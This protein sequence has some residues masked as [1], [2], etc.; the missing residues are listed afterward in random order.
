W[1]ASPGSCLNQ[2]C[3][4]HDRCYDDIQIANNECFGVSCTWAAQT[5]SCDQHFFQGAAACDAC[6]SPCNIPCHVIRWIASFAASHNAGKC[7]QPSDAT[8][9]CD[10]GCDV[11]AS[12]G[13]VDLAT[14]EQNPQESVGPVDRFQCTAEGQTC[15][16]GQCSCATGQTLCN[17]ACVDTQS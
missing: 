13:C 8:C 1:W 11:C 3:Y 17:E 2:V 9:S 12:A 14:L 15:Q 5:T 10:Q 4:A 7:D 16:Q 6:G